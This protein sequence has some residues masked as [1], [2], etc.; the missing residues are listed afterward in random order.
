M[1][2]LTKEMSS[3]AG[4][5]DLGYSDV[6]AT[7]SI[8]GIDKEINLLTAEIDASKDITDPGLIEITNNKKK[9]LK[10][11]E[12][13]KTNLARIENINDPVE[14]RKT[15]YLKKAFTD[16]MKV[17]LDEK[18]TTLNP[19]NIG[20]AYRIFTDYYALNYDKTN[21]NKVLSDLYDPNNFIK[22]AQRERT[23]IVARDKRRA[24]FFKKAFNKYAES[25]KIGVFLKALAETGFV[26]D[27]KYLKALDTNTFDEL[28]ELIL[29][30]PDVK[31]RDLNSNKLFGSDDPRYADVKK[32]ISEFVIQVAP[33]VAET[34]TVEASSTSN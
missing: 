23:L 26:I 1:A 27:L 14:V 5:A 21:F 20:E 28:K 30:D 3:I 12:S 22:L 15:S 33:P 8:P 10:A 31:F 6:T 32:F 29:N 16:Y 25:S 18:G 24:E 7:L 9:K 2:N 11:L 13:L 17:L 19:A 4:V 34:V